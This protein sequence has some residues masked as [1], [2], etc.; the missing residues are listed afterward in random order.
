MAKRTREPEPED[1]PE[2]FVGARR[3]QADSLAR[4]ERA[5]EWAKMQG[6]MRVEVE[7]PSGRLVTYADP[8]LYLEAF[9]TEEIRQAE[10]TRRKE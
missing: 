7:T 9:A 4:L 5:K 2:E 3:R 6:L 8:A 1:E 10:R